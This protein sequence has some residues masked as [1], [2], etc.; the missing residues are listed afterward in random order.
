MR[1]TKRENDMFAKYSSL[2]LEAIN[3]FDLLIIY[4]RN[5]IK[6][7]ALINDIPILCVLTA[8]I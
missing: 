3:E 8:T 6:Q 1:R 5:Y 4:C 2:Y 7:C